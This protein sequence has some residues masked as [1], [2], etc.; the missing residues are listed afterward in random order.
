MRMRAVSLISAFLMCCALSACSKP[1]ATSTA[2]SQMSDST[3]SSSASANSMATSTATSEAVPA[4]ASP[5]APVSDTMA[6]KEPVAPIAP[7]V[8]PA[9][10]TIS[11]RMGESISAKTAEVGQTFTATVATPVTVSH[12]TVI[13]AGANAS[14]TVTAAK[15]QGRFKGEGTLGLTL[16]SVT[17]NGA[18]RSIT[19][20][21]FSSTQKGKGKRTAVIVGGGTG[22]GALIGGLAGGGKGAAIGALAGAG[23]GTAGS[24]YTGNKDV[25]VPAESIISFKLTQP[26]TIKR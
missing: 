6:T 21:D 16:T 19:T 26:V 18:E 1:P 10:T 15:G 11:V 14:G 17:V 2:T 12:K 7:L 20:S 22:V 5:P 9:G 25:A 24:A 23:A 3:T 8:I 13:P 4:P